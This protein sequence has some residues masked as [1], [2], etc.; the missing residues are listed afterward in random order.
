MR[1][2]PVWLLRAKFTYISFHFQ[3]LVTEFTSPAGA[4]PMWMINECQFVL[5]YFYIF[6]C[7]Y[8]YSG[9]D[10]RSKKKQKQKM[11]EYNM[12]AEPKSGDM[13]AF[14]DQEVRKDHY[15]IEPFQCDHP[16]E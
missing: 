7:F 8:L 2:V 14:V 13:D 3:I 12:K 15:Q 11:R 4:E 1:N 6:L 5:P 9:K 16:S 10:G